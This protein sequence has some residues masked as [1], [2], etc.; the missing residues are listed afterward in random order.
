[1]LTDAGRGLNPYLTVETTDTVTAVRRR[2]AGYAL[3][4]A[5]LGSGGSLVLATLAGQNGWIEYTMLPV[6]LLVSIATQV[7]LWQNRLSVRTVEVF[8][9]LSLAA[10][11]I[12]SLISYALSGAMYQNGFSSTAL[13]FPLFYPIAFMIFK[14]RTAMRVSLAYYL[15]ALAFGLIGLA[16]HGPP[17]PNV[18]N[19][20]MQ[21][22]VANPAY[23]LLF[24]VYIQWRKEYTSM[25]YMAHTD[26]LTGLPNRRQMQQL[27]QNELAR[28][29]R[30]TA[31]FAVLL[32][33]LDFFKEVND[34]FGHAVGDEV[35]KEVGLRLSKALRVPDT[36][37]RW[38][39]EEFM[40]LA[41][42][43]SDP[44]ACE[45]AERLAQVVRETPFIGKIQL[46]TSIGVACHRP[47]DTS[48]DMINR[49]DRAL[50][51]AKHLGRNSVV[52]DLPVA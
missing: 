44:Q 8:F 41:P 7:L 28:A 39:G 10:Y 36:L 34:Q 42:A 2:V 43:T 15:V 16:L 12:T 25:R 3:Y 24:Y 31:P 35:L 5:I 33:D 26:T 21:F 19:S 51:R 37:A 20:L 47:G 22:Y 13:W 52:T 29:N 14:T 45:L 18:S 38:G 32:V 23:L 50:Y 9:A 40:V 11:Q 30:Y 4:A 17:N 6:I 49:A 46:T 48:E 1:M 27:L